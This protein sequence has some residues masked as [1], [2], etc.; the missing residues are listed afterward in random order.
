[1]ATHWHSSSTPHGVLAH[2]KP[3]G[4]RRARLTA[5]QHAH[6]HR[7]LNPSAT[8]LLLC[9]LPRRGTC[10]VAAVIAGASQ[11]RGRCAVRAVH[12]A[13]IIASPRSHALRALREQE[14]TR[15]G[16]CLGAT[17]RTSLRPGLHDGPATLETRS[18]TPEAPRTRQHAPPAWLA[19]PPPADC[20]PAFASG[21]LLHPFE[22]H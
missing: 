11:G 3:T 2:S 17:C 10:K 8:R 9:V 7:S 5:R 4:I 12:F 20:Q 14:V 22:D 19:R 15:Q 6:V 1:M 18:P 13:T 21:P 16:G